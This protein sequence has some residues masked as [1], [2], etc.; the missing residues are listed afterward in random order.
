MARRYF[1]KDVEELVIWY[2]H[3]VS[4]LSLIAGFLS[5]NFILLK[6][7]DLWRTNLLLLFYLIVCAF[8]IVAINLIA[9]GHVKNQSIVRK[10][11]VIPI[12]VQFAFGGLFSGYLS[13]YSRSAS[14]ATSWIFVVVLACLLFGNERFMRFY[15]LF[16]FQISLYFGALFSFLIF[17]LP[18][19][20]HQIG[21][22]MFLLSGAVSLGIITVFLMAL[23]R[24]VPEI[25][26]LNRT[27]VA[28]SIAIIYVVFNALYFFNL[29]PPLPLSIKSA[30]VYHSVIHESDGTY[31]LTGEVLP[32]Y[33]T[34]LNYND[35][36]HQTLGESVYVY[37][38]IFAPNDL[39]TTIE[40][41]WQYYDQAARAWQT[42]DTLRFP[43]LGGREDGYEGYSVDDNV[44]A[45]DWRVNV[46]T[47]YGQLIG[48]VSFSVVEVADPVPFVVTSK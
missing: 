24:M 39:S 17:F 5:D 3:Y 46:I 41:Q 13:L 42:T 7:V 1:P 47:S 43:I 38:S 4:P 26:K 34:Y 27:K 19:V 2:Q 25:V 6:R 11:P 21:P 22:R 16:A 40:Y 15:S 12:A 48:R 10:A 9:A 35:I 8:G 33:E 44:T 32:W 28:R 36:F 45:G 29:I 20:F 30:G 18:V 31:Q 23:Y 14:L 37:T